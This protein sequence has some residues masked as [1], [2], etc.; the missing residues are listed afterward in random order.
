[1]TRSKVVKKSASKRK[2]SNLNRS[3]FKPASSLHLIN[4]LNKNLRRWDLQCI[5]AELSDI[6]KSLRLDMLVSW[7]RHVW[8]NKT[9]NTANLSR[10]LIK[11]KP[12]WSNFDFLWK[13]L[14]S[15]PKKTLIIESV[16]ECGE[17]SFFQR[18]RWLL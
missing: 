14:Q 17:T 18:W 2:N 16:V 13:I 1:M 9:K 6:E 11:L 4:L 15:F 5:P 7:R 12:L 3:D 8:N 10:F